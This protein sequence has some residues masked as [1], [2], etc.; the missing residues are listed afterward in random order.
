MS[1]RSKREYVEAVFLR[2]KK[3]SRGEKTKILDEF[4]ATSGYHRKHA[5]RVLRSFKRFTRS[6]QKRKGRPPVYDAGV[7]TVPLKRIWLGANLPCS[8]RLKA[9]LPL[10]LPGYV[11]HFGFLPLEV[12]R[13]LRKISPSTIDRLLESVR[14]SYEKHGMST[15]KPGTLLRKHIPILTNQWNESRPG[16][17]EADTVA[18]CGQSMAG[19]FTYTI[20][21]V[22]IATGWTEQ[23]AVWGR[24]ETGVLE[25]I[26]D[27]ED[28]LP[29]TLLGFD[30]DNG[31]EF[32]NH[33]LVRHF[34][35]RKNLL[36][37]PGAERI[38]KTITPISNRRTG[39][40]CDNG[41][42]TRDWTIWT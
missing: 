42:D 17:L 19:V 1:P 9:I 28:L 32:L 20:D 40:M 33:H 35:Q 2:Y 22:D 8:K 34:A 18:H 11:E 25:Q 37:S 3:A 6:K 15:T 29:F 36:P 12:V 7:L 23:R 4:C 41:W 14:I 16:F 21:L 38:T 24:G 39:P 10:W 13:A 26:K 5:I 31:S 30:C 27:V